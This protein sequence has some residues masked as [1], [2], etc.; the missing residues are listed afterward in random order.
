MKNKY[1]LG[2]LTGI[3]CTAL[4]LGITFTGYNIL[5]NNNGNTNNFT[6]GTDNSN[7]NEATSATI[8]SELQRKLNLIKGLVSNYYLGEVTEEQYQTGM[9]KGLMEALDDPYSCYYTKEEYASLMESSSGVYC[10]IG[11]YVSQNVTTGIITIVK[12]FVD[13][14][15]YNAGILP[16]DTIYK[17]NGE[18]V[19]GTDL[20]KVVGN[21]KGEEGTEVTVTIVREG[22]KEPVDY[23]IKRGTVEVPTIAFEMLED[24]IG[25]IYVSEFDEITVTQFKSAISELEDQGMK[26]LVIDVRDN[27]GGLLDACVKMLDRLLPKGLLVYQEDKNGTRLSENYADNKEQLDVPMAVIVNG[28]SASAS[29]I[30][31]GA[32]QDYEKATI[33]GTQS[34]GKGIVQ[35]VFPIGDGSAIKVTI[36]KYFTPKGRNIHGTGIEPD[37]IVELDESLAKKVVIEHEEDNQLQAA[38]EVVKDQLNGK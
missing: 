12:P 22:E 4:L 3:L 32:L 30:F 35:S 33:V 5:G 31:S 8:N 23:V 37:K 6:Q 20:T 7:D 1:L 9:L 14:P 17:V 27:P 26:G 2:L 38:I 25:Y 34:F 10:G 11:A 18:E 21:M 16:G 28:N 13:G 19:T 15:A 36:S 29:E 24:K